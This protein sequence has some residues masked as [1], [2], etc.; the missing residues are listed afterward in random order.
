MAGAH[1]K[2]TKRFDQ[3]TSVQRRAALGAMAKHLKDA[4]ALDRRLKKEGR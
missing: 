4:K 3:L 1:D 2:R